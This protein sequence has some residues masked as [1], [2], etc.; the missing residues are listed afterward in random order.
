ML[1]SSSLLLLGFVFGMRHATD[2]DHVVAVSTIVMRRPQLGEASI[3]GALWG[4]GHTVT[5]LLVGGAMLLFRVAM[6][7]RLGLSLELLVGMM[8]V[9]LGAITL[10]DRRVKALEHAMRPVFVGFVHGLAGS[11]FVAMLVLGT[12]TDALVG[13]MYLLVFGAGTVV[14]MMLI[15]L[16][17]AA[18]SLLAMRRFE[19]VQRYLRIATGV[20]SIVF[21][22]VIAHHVG[23]TDGLF[24]AA[25]RWMPR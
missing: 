16:T 9:V 21:G 13:I 4:I 23:I 15:T 10:S 14:G 22:L 17:I 5:I 2:P 3:V 24:S 6:P 12:V 1:S 8:L 25:P 7:P 18:P 20:A 19:H 11:A